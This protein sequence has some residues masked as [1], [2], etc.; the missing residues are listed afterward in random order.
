MEEPFVRMQ[1]EN[2]YVTKLGDKPGD[3]LKQSVFDQANKLRQ[4]KGVPLFV[5]DARLEQAAQKHAAALAAGTARPH[6]G[7]PE[8]LYQA[9]FPKDDNC[10]ISRMRCNVTEGIVQTPT[11][12]D[13]TAL[14]VLVSS[15]PGEGHYDDFYDAKIN[16]VGIGTGEGSVGYLHNHLVLDYGRLCDVHPDP[17]PDPP[18]PDWHHVWMGFE[19]CPDVV[20]SHAELKK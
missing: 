5:Y 2:P 8:R 3:A 12:L 18:K 14:A 13:N 17:E 20:V 15:G 9:G 7:W 4:A 19:G 1:S 10:F 11:G 6:D 16:R